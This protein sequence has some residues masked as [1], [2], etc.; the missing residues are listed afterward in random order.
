MSIT[1][2]RSRSQ[3]FTIEQLAKILETQITKEVEAV[4]VLDQKKQT[5]YTEIEY[6]G[7]VGGRKMK[8]KKRAWIKNKEALVMTYAAEFESFD[9]YLAEVN[10]M[11]DSF[12]VR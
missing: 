12:K 9:K 8:W 4:R 7:N 10:T 2:Q 6:T 5:D 11:M 3:S 1:L